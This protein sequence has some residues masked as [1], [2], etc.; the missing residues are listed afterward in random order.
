MRIENS[1]PDL[2]SM[3]SISSRFLLIL[4]GLNE[5][6]SGVFICENYYSCESCMFELLPHPKRVPDASNAK[7][8]FP[9]ADIFFILRR[10]GYMVYILLF[11]SDRSLFAPRK[12][13]KLV[14][15]RFHFHID[16]KY[17]LPSP[18]YLHSIWVLSNDHLNKLIDTACADLFTS[19]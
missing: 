9:A 8:W 2:M 4:I 10:C 3:I 18:I 6:I 12:E 7:Q 15:V 13:G 5:Q 1:S 19:F 11:S 16:H 14:E 17:R